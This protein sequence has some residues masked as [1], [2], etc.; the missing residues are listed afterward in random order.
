MTKKSKK[1]K[2]E[3]EYTAICM[4]RST[5]RKVRIIAAKMETSIGRASEKLIELGL[6]EYERAKKE[7]MELLDTQV[8][9]VQG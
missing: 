7:N 6:T 5:K 8:G 2:E 1:R 4:T 3:T 9:A